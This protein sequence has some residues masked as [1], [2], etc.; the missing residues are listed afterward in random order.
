[1]FLAHISVPLLALVT[2]RFWP[3]KVWENPEIQDGGSKTGAIWQS[4]TYRQNSYMRGKIRQIKIKSSALK[5]N[6]FIS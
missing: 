5:P 1:M 3:P 4:Q 2:F 6:V